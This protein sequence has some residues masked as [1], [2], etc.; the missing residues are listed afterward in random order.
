M[1]GGYKVQNGY[2]QVTNAVIVFN[3]ESKTL[4]DAPPMNE[5]RWGHGS[6]TIGRNIYVFA[7]G[8]RYGSLSSIEVLDGVL[9]D[10]SWRLLQ[11]NSRSELLPRYF[12]ILCPIGPSSILICGGVT[13]GQN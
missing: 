7:G 3:L 11:S 9:K 5:P 1:T 10:T 6:T 2:Y 8:A 4:S 12:P 13:K